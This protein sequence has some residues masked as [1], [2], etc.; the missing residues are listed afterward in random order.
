MILP[1]IASEVMDRETEIE[2][3]K[4]AVA[5]GRVVTIVGTGISVAATDGQKIEGFPVA[6]WPGLLSHGAK[7][8]RDLGLAD[9]GDVQLWNDQIASGK[10]NFLISAAQDITDRLRSASPGVFRGWLKDT[11]GKL[12]LRDRALIDALAN[13]PGVLATLN[14]DGLLSSATG[15]RPVTWQNADAVQ[16][17]LLSD[18]ASAVLHLHGHWEAPESVVLGLESYLRVKTEPHARA[19]LD[20]FTIDR[21]LLFVGC[22]DTIQ[23]PNFTRLIEWAEAA[24]SDVSPRHFL[25]CRTGQL[26]EFRKKLARAPWLR[27]LDFGA[28]YTDL[29]AFVKSLTA[30]GGQTRAAGGA[31]KTSVRLDLEAYKHAIRKRYGKLKL[32]E[33]D[34]TTHDIRA[35]TLTGMFIAPSAKE[36]AEF[37]P[38]L[39]ELP[40]DL[41]GRLSEAGKAD[42]LRKA[43]GP[44]PGRPLEDVDLPEKALTESHKAYLAQKPRSVLEILADPSLSRLVVLGD[45][46]SGKSTLLQ[47]QL[48]TW[49]DA[50]GAPLPVLI[51]LREYARLRQLGEVEGFLDFLGRGESVRHRL[52]PTALDAWLRSKPTL[53]L[54][55]GLDEIFD[56]ELRKEVTSAVQ[57]FADE[58]S[59]HARFVVTSRVIGYQHQSWRD[60]NFRA[61][62]LQELDREQRTAFLARWHRD[63]YEDP[64]QGKRKRELLAKALDDSPA[65]RQLA[66]NPLLLTMMAI[67]NRTQ[68]LPRDR[69][70][71]YEQCSRLLLHQWKVEPAL[72][73]DPELAKASLDFKDKRGLLLR[74]ARAMQNTR[75]GLTANLI[76]ESTLESALASGLMGIPGLRPDRAARALIEQLRGRNFML[77]SVGAGTYAFVHRTFLEY[78]C[79]LD[80]RERFQTERA[81]S[82]G[83]LKTEVFAHFHDEN[84]HE[85]LSLLAGMLAPTFAGQMI[86]YLLD[87]AETENGRNAVLLA[88]RCVGEVRKR[89][90]IEAV[91]KRARV[92]L[93]KLAKTT[94]SRSRLRLHSET[95]R[96]VDSIVRLVA[97]WPEGEATFAF[98]LSLVDDSDELVV[99]QALQQLKRGWRNHP[100]T[101]AAI[102]RVVHASGTIG[103]MAE[104][105]LVEYWGDD[106]ESHELLKSLIEDRFTSAE[107]SVVGKIASLASALVLHAIA[108]RWRDAPQTLPW[109]ISLARARKD[110]EDPILKVLERLW[111]DHPDVVALLA[112]HGAPPAGNSQT[113]TPDAA[114]PSPDK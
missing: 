24:L 42:G 9:D 52:E 49:A 14:Y 55:D 26:E 36:L 23:D 82:E 66:G 71:L 111:P 100:Q 80:I 56:G 104:F 96:R 4:S 72:A 88:A 91:E 114:P 19:V 109:I 31:L 34:A 61:F 54:F 79:A 105:T 106:Q 5:S 78:F 21:T 95:D 25:L 28:E 101:L 29:L 40:K 3:L 53:V 108:Q 113:T 50:G 64:E 98:L 110:S 112:A 65:I 7:H 38:R 67:L 97:T 73:Q 70:E 60:E 59:D 33:L 18:G 37:M 1:V 41:Q 83:Q 92:Q 45:P 107:Q 17:V 94:P 58:Y 86:D 10:T 77:C 75:E 63:A 22:G 90:E 12:E 102:K 74:V 81:L 46:G 51:E 103:Q 85:V 76:D 47:Y 35:L 39:F 68:D 43:S 2:K 15:R 8:A 6:T 27:P 93:E 44:S 87:Q 11:V 69:A 48:L 57:R 99:S 89:H 62:M 32:E 16:D 20:L 84:W 13:L 30:A